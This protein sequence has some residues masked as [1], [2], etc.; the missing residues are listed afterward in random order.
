MK[1]LAAFLAFMLCI[2]LAACGKGNND[3]VGE[4]TLQPTQTVTATEESTDGNG[5]VEY[6]NLIT[7]ADYEKHFEE[8]GGYPDTFITYEELQELGTFKSFVCQSYVVHEDSSQKEYTEYQ[9][10]LEADGAA[11][12][13]V[14]RPVKNIPE[15]TREWFDAEDTIIAADLR[16]NLTDGA[17]ASITREK[18]QYDYLYGKLYSIE[19]IAGETQVMIWSENGWPENDPDTLIGRLLIWDTAEAAITELQQKLDGKLQGLKYSN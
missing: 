13:V 3:N 4:T 6:L 2:S 18:Y 14:V 12:N 15:D 5:N 10:V 16:T 7:L 9:Y 19:W 11:F 1:H 17:R 8:A